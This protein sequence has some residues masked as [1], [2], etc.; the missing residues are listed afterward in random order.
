MIYCEVCPHRCPL[1]ET[2]RGLCGA[3]TERAG[4]SFPLN[5]GIAT[6]LHLD[7]IE[8]KP[9]WHFHP[10]SQILSYGSFGCNLRC[11]FCQNHEIS[12]MRK[13]TGDVISPGDL[14]TS[15]ESMKIYGNIGVAF[16]YNE[17]TICPEFIV[18][19][20]QLVH[21]K[22]MQNVVVTNGYMTQAT[23]EQLLT[24]TDA[25]NID[26]KGFTDGFYRKIGGTLDPVKRSIQ[27]AAEHA[28]LE[29]TTLV[30]PGEND[31]DEEMSA[32]SSWLASIDRGIPLHLS[33]F[34]PGYLMVDKP[35][36][37]K[38]TLEHLQGVA[39]NHLDRVYL[40]NV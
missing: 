23:M 26:L 28:H 13:D 16:T 33:R 37:P 12:M 22:G 17:P 39:A 40:G 8:K 2:T 9:L 15:A 30:I 34:F 35:P 1:T 24:V 10:G 11:T 27:I 5:Y 14:A 4:R 7:P 31:S 21:Q 29:V 32:L 25:F 19:T 18:D 6:T 20:G 3:R 36:T 38:A